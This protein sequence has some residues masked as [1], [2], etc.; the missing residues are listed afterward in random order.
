M[1]YWVVPLILAAGWAVPANA[2]WVRAES[3]HFIAP[4]LAW[5]VTDRST[6][7]I[8]TGFGLTTNSDPYLV[9][10]GWAYELPRVGGR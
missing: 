2:E 3:R 1:K 9:R 6:L 7:K 8:S 5:H 10:A 4:V